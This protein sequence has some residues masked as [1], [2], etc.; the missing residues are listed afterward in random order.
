M[1]C[2]E[3]HF[4]SWLRFIKKI[5]DKN[6]IDLYIWKIYNTKMIYALNQHVK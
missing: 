6:S 2:L 1:T 4:T 5:N 3:D